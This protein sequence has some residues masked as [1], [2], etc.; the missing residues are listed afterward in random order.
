MSSKGR[1]PHQLRRNGPMQGSA[2]AVAINP[3]ILTDYQRKWVRDG[4]DAVAKIIEH[5]N[6]I[7]LE[8]DRLAR[9]PRRGSRGPVCHVSVSRRSCGTAAESTRWCRPGWS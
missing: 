6:A 4:Q 9:A 3:D 2:L 1:T 8:K 7:T 5:E